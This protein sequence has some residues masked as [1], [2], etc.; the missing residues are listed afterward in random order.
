MLMRSVALVNVIFFLEQA[1]KSLNYEEYTVEIKTADVVE[2]FEKGVIVLVTGC[3]ER[4]M[5]E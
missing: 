1:I 2:S 3:L 4:T 5:W